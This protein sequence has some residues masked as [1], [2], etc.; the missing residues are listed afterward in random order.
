MIL[1]KSCQI[2]QFGSNILSCSEKADI[3]IVNHNAH[4]LVLTLF[5]I[6][7]IHDDFIFFL[8]IRLCVMNL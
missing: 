3:A 5:I 2:K 1:A 7:C 6:D 8:N 4:F